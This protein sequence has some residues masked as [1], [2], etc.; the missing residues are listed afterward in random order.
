MKALLKKTILVAGG[1]F[2]P[3][4]VRA[5]E[6]SVQV[7]GKS[8]TKLE[9]PITSLTLQDF[10][11]KILGVVIKIGYPV[12]ILFIIY[13]GFLFVKA[14][15]NPEELKKAKSTFLW[16]IIGTAVLLGAQV[17]ALAIGGTIQQLR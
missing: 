17:L 4:V 13:S 9:N 5:A 11:I 12:A 7:G 6:I 1:F 2:L 8:A 14:R 16:T 15:G 10:I 3:L